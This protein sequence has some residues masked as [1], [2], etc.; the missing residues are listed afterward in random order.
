MTA[1]DRRLE[2]KEKAAQVEEVKEIA[3]LSR[4]SA[5]SREPAGR[6][7]T[8][9]QAAPQAKEAPSR[10]E[11]AKSAPPRMEPVKEDIVFERRESPPPTVKP[12]SAAA[13]PSDSPARPAGDESAIEDKVRDVLRSF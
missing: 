8:P 10:T 11:P 9:P 3:D 5:E 2:W 12:A 4:S 6:K 1:R 7:E 13:P